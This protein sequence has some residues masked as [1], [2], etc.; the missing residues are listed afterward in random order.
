MSGGGGCSLE[1]AKHNVGKE[2][3]SKHHDMGTGTFWKNSGGETSG[4]SN[5]NNGGGW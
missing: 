5:D 1:F 3:A 4:G 2:K